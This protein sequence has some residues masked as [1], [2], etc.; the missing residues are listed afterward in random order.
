MYAAR[1][2]RG[3]ELTMLEWAKRLDLAKEGTSRDGAR[4]HAECLFFSYGAARTV[5]EP[6]PCGRIN[7]LLNG[8]YRQ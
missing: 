4:R 5:L 6:T 1:E 2:P 7:L 3:Y 8:R